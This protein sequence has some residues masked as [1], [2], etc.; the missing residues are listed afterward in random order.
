MN[1]KVIVAAHKSYEMPADPMYLPVQVGRDLHSPI[2]EFHGDNTGSNISRMNPNYCEL[3][4]LYWAWKNVQADYLGLAHYRRLFC[5]DSWFF[6]TR[7]NKRKKIMT[8][9]KAAKLLHQFDAILPKKRR[10]WIETI[11]SHYVHTHFEK[12][13]D[14]A[15]EIIARHYPMYL[16]SFD[17]VMTRRSAHMFNMFIMKKKLA[18][19]YTSWLFDILFRMDQQIDIS[20]YSAYQARIFGY[21][22]ELLLDVWFDVNKVN[23]VEM[24]VMFM[25]NQHWPRKIAKFLRLKFFPTK[26]ASVSDKEKSEREVIE[27]AKAR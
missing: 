21:I 4:A 12:D 25:E 7:N 23:Y 22:G 27:A 18:D 5:V 17:K 26:G 19:H 16:A 15:R 14:C 10:Y 13:L 1:I 8:S 6:G 20:T 24:P 3:T 11:R 2:Q 9:D